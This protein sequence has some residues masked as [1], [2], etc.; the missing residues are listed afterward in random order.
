MSEKIETKEDG[1]VKAEPIVCDKVYSK[2][3][4]KTAKAVSGIEGFVLGALA[5]LTAGVILSKTARFNIIDYSASLADNGIEKIK[6]IPSKFRKHN[7]N[8][9][10]EE[11]E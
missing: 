3:E 10:I 8:E 7:N 5:T 2:K 9:S 1:F 4:I 11:K 6:S